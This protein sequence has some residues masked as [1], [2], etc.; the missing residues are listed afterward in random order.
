MAIIFPDNPQIGDTTTTG[1]ASWEWDG[2][3]WLKLSD[4]ERGETGYT[5]SLGYT[6]SRGYTGSVGYA[7]STGLPGGAPK[8]YQTFIADGLTTRYTLNYEVGNTV[9]IFVIV[10]GLVLI[11]NADY[12][13]ENGNELLLYDTPT[14]LADIEIRFFNEA[15]YNGS[16]GYQGSVGYRGSRGLDGLAT[17]YVSPVAPP[18]EEIIP[19]ELW[20]DTENGILNIW[21][22]GETTWVGIQQGPRGLRGYAGSYGFTGSLGYT[23]SIGPKGDSGF[24]G[25][26]GTTGFVGSAGTNGGLGF[27]GSAGTNGTNGATGFAG[28][29][30]VAGY[31]GSSG[32]GGGGNSF[33][34]MSLSGYTDIVADSPQDSFGMLTGTGIKFASDGAALTISATL[35]EDYINIGSVSGSVTLDVNTSKVFKVLPTSSYSF[36]FTNVSSIPN[37]KTTT[38]VVLVDQGATARI[39]TSVSYDGTSQ[40]IKWQGGTTPTGNANKIDAISF[41]LL[42]SSSGNI[43]L[44]QL[45]GFG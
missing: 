11:P 8:N 28:S 30:G 44:A 31:T 21:Y 14:E 13:V 27:T 45:I 38:F 10:N 43:T 9:S 15:G 7:G 20:W 23:G 6:G 41:T 12:T 17:V 26:R 33:S 35:I 22:T 2:E 37:N 24:A 19:G 4:L 3:R 36:N 18:A 34:R 25:S 5:G 32:D 40:T 42:K 1:G 29:R 39:P 16:V